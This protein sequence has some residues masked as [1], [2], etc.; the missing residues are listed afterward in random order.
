MASN[1]TSPR[2]SIGGEEF[3]TV[4][5]MKLSPIEGDGATASPPVPVK[6]MP[7]QAMYIFQNK[8]KDFS[9]QKICPPD[10]GQ[11]GSLPRLT[12][13]PANKPDYVADFH[14]ISLMRI[15]DDILTHKHSGHIDGSFN[16]PGPSGG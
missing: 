16:T 13:V 8:Y 12:G 2:I 15:I 6:Q 7:S 10:Y 1:G 4:K 5:R 9:F 14:F 11:D 3:I